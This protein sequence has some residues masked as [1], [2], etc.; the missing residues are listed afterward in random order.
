M[1]D[2]KVLAVTTWT[3]LGLLV[4]FTVAINLGADIIG[5][6]E[7]KCPA[8]KDLNPDCRVV[9][10]SSIAVGLTNLDSP[11]NDITLT[12]TKGVKNFQNTGS[13]PITYENNFYL[14]APAGFSLSTNATKSNY[15]ACALFFIA[16]SDQVKFQGNISTATGTCS[17]AIT[18]D[19]LNAILKQATDAVTAFKGSSTAE[20]CQALEADFNNNLNFKCSQF[21]TGDRWDGLH[22]QGTFC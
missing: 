17:D 14:G 12:W 16:V 3:F 9:N 6:T 20:N 10:R 13:P 15:D 11:F 18:T 19:C 7:L 4:R 1:F 22:V 21:A 2:V 5:C 8:A